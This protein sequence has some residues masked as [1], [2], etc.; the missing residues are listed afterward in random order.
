[1]GQEHTS[2]SLESPKLKSKMSWAPSLA[3]HKLAIVVI[4][5]WNTALGKYEQ[6]LRSA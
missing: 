2:F 3:P 5:V 1:M 4:H 6:S